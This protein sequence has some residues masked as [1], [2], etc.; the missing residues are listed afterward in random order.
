MHLIEGVHNYGGVYAGPHPAA[1]RAAAVPRGPDP[2]PPPRLPPVRPFPGLPTSRLHAMGFA[3]HKSFL[4]GLWQYQV[5]VILQ[6]GWLGMHILATHLNFFLGMSPCYLFL[7]PQMALCTY[8]QAVGSA[9]QQY[10]FIHGHHTKNVLWFQMLHVTLRHEN[11][12]NRRWCGQTVGSRFGI[13]MCVKICF[14]ALPLLPAH[15]FSHPLPLL[16]FN[17]WLQFQ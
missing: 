2:P 10:S 17:P 1:T 5:V 4:V 6:D 13:V 7:F 15:I 9:C 12:E 14:H 8:K 11:E 16:L 3:L